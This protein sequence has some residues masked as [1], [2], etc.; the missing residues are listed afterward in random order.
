MVISVEVVAAGHHYCSW[1][2]SEDLYPRAQ[3]LAFE[4]CLCCSLAMSLR[5]A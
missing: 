3:P 2:I 4:F 1:D 5:A